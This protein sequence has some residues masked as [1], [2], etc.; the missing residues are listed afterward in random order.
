MQLIANPPLD[1]PMKS[2]L[3]SA[4]ESRQRETACTRK[5]TFHVY[6]VYRI[7]VDNKIEN[8]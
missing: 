2:Q 1:I 5:I 6:D 4:S 7:W 8:I 3:R